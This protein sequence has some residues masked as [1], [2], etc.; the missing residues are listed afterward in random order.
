MISAT[1][2]ME[3]HLGHRSY[4]QNLRRFID[5]SELVDVNWVN[6]TYK[7]SKTI[8]NH[9]PLLPEKLRGPIIGRAQARQGLR[10]KPADVALFNTQVPAVLGGRMVRQQPYVICTDI[11]PIQYDQMGHHYG[12]QP[13]RVGF[14][15]WYKNHVNRGLFQKADRILSWSN[16]V[17]DSL[18]HDYDILPERI[19]VL[20]PG[21]DLEIWQPKPRA[22]NDG[23][24]LR[25]LFIGGDFYRKGGEDLLT[26]VNML[27]A[28]SV[29]LVLVT[30]SPIPADE[31]ITVYNDMRPNS[32]E[33]I[34][35]S[36]SCDLFVIPTK[37]EAFGIAAVEAGALGLPVI[38]TA[39]GGLV[40][41]VAD[42]E[43]GFLIQP[44]DMAALAAHMRQL[45]EDSALRQ[46]LG[47]AG[48]EQAQRKFDARKNAARVIEIL[49][50][51][52]NQT[53]TFDH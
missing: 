9:I 22:H 5:P 36:Q 42:G 48:R 45:V 35:L 2:V 51:T 25:V 40:D 37:A 12:H 24:P 7:Q 11:T 44:G 39:V 33:L 34:A 31:H 50:E 15:R 47:Q 53:T 30:R 21:V 13:D 41:T 29:E 20:P 14:I 49:Q 32:P 52:V 43:T 8:W 4:F 17:R 18:I 28:G 3:Q 23:D 38:A 10:E 46:Q 6:V 1:F 16:W 26:A 19:E 27:P